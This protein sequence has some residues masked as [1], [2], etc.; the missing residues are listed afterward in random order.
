M[1]AREDLY[2]RAIRELQDDLDT[3]DSD[4]KRALRKL[5]ATKEEISQ[6]TGRMT[7][8]QQEFQS[9]ATSRD[10]AGAGAHRSKAATG[11]HLLVHGT[12]GL[13][14]ASV[15]WFAQSEHAALQWKLIFSMFFP[16]RCRWAGFCFCISGIVHS[17]GQ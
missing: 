6:L 13:A 15:W 14:I 12:V 3:K 4:R 5:K 10:S 7:V 9:N 11:T 8:L 2:R 1:H 17:S 16:V